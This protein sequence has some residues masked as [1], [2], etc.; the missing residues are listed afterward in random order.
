MAE[1][2][3]S[4]V[5][6]TETSNTL[7]EVFDLSWLLGVLTLLRSRGEARKMMKKK[8]KIAF[9]LQFLLVFAFTGTEVVAQPTP[10]AGNFA[11]ATPCPTIAE[12]LVDPH[13]LCSPPGPE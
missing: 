1:A 9:F 4:V 7:P 6:H 13:S 8:K 12:F 3:H 10:N 5:A 2:F 11:F